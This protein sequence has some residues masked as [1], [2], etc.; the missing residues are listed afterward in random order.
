MILRFPKALHQAYWMTRGAAE[1][2]YVVT[3]E[4]AISRAPTVSYAVIFERE[5]AIARAER[6]RVLV[7][8]SDMQEEERRRAGARR[9]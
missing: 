3:R 9:R 7:K 8:V 4:A 6:F 2:V 1:P 5:L